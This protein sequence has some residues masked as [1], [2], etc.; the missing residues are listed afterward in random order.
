[1]FYNVN[2]AASTKTANILAGDINEFVPVPSVVTIYGVSSA[3]GVNI[4]VLADSDVAINDKEIPFI[5]T[6]LVQKDQMFD[7]FAVA[8]G[9]RMAIFLRE[10]AASATTDVYTKIEVTPIG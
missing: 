1:M 10:T 7:S 3:I 5:G 9:T 2:L 4:T 6:S 8:G